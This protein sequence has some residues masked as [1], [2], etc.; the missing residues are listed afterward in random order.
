MHRQRGRHPRA[1]RSSFATWG[2]GEMKLRVDST[3]CQ[4][5]MLCAMLAPDSF[6]LSDDD[7]HATAKFEFVSTQREH[8]VVEASEVCPEQ[9]IIIT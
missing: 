7:G 3:R 2:A 1:S 4:A 9:A 6:E 8:E 5:H